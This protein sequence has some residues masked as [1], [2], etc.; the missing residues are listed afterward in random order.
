MLRQKNVSKIGITMLLTIMLVLGFTICN[1][2]VAYA[3]TFPPS[4]TKM[5]DVNGK[6]I[7]N[8]Y[9]NNATGKNGGSSVLGSDVKNKVNG[10]SKDSMDLVGTVVMAL[11]IIGMFFT[12]MKFKGLGDNPQKKSIL[13][14]TLIGEFIGLIFIANIFGFLGFSLTN[15]QL[16]G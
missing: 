2:N 8:G 14:I 3:S 6:D 7:I 11:Y 9:I 10:L 15:F 16:F 1:K 4:A 12:A 13:K 5:A